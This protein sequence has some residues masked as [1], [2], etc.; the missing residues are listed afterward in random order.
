MEKIAIVGECPY[1]PTSFGK[2]VRYLAL[3]LTRK[4]YDIVCYCP[5]AYVSFEKN[6]VEYR[7]VRVYPL[8]TLKDI[9]VEKPDVTLFIGSPH[10]QPLRD[11]LYECDKSNTICVGYFMI[12]TLSI[13]PE[14]LY[15]LLNVSLFATPSKY[16]RRVFIDHVSLLGFR[17]DRLMKRAFT[18][19]HGIDFNEHEK[20]AKR[21]KPLFDNDKFVFSFFAKNHIRKNIGNLLFAYA[22]I[23]REVKDSVLFLA[24]I[25]YPGKAW[26]VDAIVKQ[27]SYKYPDINEHIIVLDKYQRT[28]GLTEEQVVRIYR[29]SNAFVFPTEGESFGL[30]LVEASFHKIPVITSNH[31]IVKEILN[32]PRE[33]LVK[34]YEYILLDG[35]V[36][37]K[38]VIHDLAR[39]MKYVY[40]LC[41]ED[42]KECRQIREYLHKQSR[43]YSVENMVEGIAKLV[44]KAL[45]IGRNPLLIYAKK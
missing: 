22:R 40:S 42:T 2:I 24:P 4:G 15:P 6:Y 23:Y 16:A 33:L 25:D 28:T 8:R 31:P 1:L 14:V 20:L 41:R 13:N 36:L 38:P 27:L 39:K 19:Y 11:L 35:S 5:T 34:T 3:G 44:E 37:V 43:R 17:R 29:S 26:E 32:P 12:E 21:V 30:P 7:G 10:A 18:I 45:M 9:S